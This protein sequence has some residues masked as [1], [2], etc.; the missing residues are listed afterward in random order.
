MPRLILSDADE[1]RLRRKENLTD[2]RRHQR[3]FV[4][5]LVDGSFNKLVEFAMENPKWG[6]EVRSDEAHCATESEAEQ[7]AAEMQ[8]ENSQVQ[9]ENEVMPFPKPTRIKLA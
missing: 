5:F 2:I 8:P 6:F 9:A 7:K 3:R 4:G 1:H